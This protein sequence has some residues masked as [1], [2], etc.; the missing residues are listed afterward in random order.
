MKFKGRTQSSSGLGFRRDI[1]A[2]R[3]L[4]VLAVLLFHANESYFPLG[5]LGVDVFFVIS[6]F[7]VTPLIL[8]IFVEQTNGT[9]RRVDLMYFF[10]RRFYRLAPALAVTLIFSI[11]LILFL[12]KGSDHEFFVKQGVAT[13][14]LFGNFGAFKYSYGDYFSPSP[15]PLVHTWSLSV[16]EQIYI[17]LPLALVL[18]LHKRKNIRRIFEITFVIITFTSIFSFLNPSILQPLYSQIS[19]DVASQ[20]S[21]YS[22]VD[23]IWQFTLGGLGFFLLDRFSSR[24]KK[25]SLL[26]QGLLI[27]VLL[28]LLFGPI[29]LNLKFSSIFASFFAFVIITAR[30]LD[31]LPKVVVDKLQWLGDRSYSIYL[32]HMPLLYIAK[33]SPVTQIGN[34]ED[35][36]IQS[37]IAVA[38][39]ILLGA[40]SYSKIENRFRNVDKD[41]TGGVKKVLATMVPTLLIPLSLFV[42]MEKGI[43]N[44]FWGLDRN[45]Q[46]PVAAKTLDSKCNLNFER[47]APCS[48]KVS[49]SDNIVLLIGDSYAAQYSHAVQYVAKNQNWSTSVWAMNSCRF[50][51]EKSNQNEV[52]DKCINQNRQ[53]LQWVEKNRPNKI[54]V[55]QFVKA[56]SSQHNLRNSLSA[57]KTIV[58]DILIIENTPSFPDAED[59]MIQRPLVMSPYRPPVSFKQSEMNNKD[60]KASTDLA[61]WARSNGFSTFNVEPLFCKKQ[62]CKRFSGGKWLYV[63]GNHLSVDG[64]AL[65]IPRLS[66]FLKG[67]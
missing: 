43:D 46:P 52:T 11:V 2:L 59:Y 53:I 50:L 63:D 18:I 32:L 13:L 35:R 60:L 19:I 5:Y 15:N 16:E 57:L 20:F 10:K 55:S 67:N 26:I 62:L 45:V 61:N 17:F 64:A 37:I 3:G 27:F 34:S 8:R 6:G 40:L 65:T 1:Q 23:R 66:A 38:V 41:N 22:P 51:L 9:S 36:I 28:I 25:Q 4:A 54:I 56:D 48:Y 31:V 47:F 14:L 42:T 12:G 49:G 58:P 33:Y 24:I 39:A 29:H 7:V 30:S 44:H 21:F